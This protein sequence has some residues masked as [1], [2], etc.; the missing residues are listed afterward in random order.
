[1]RIRLFK[2]DFRNESVT[3]KAVGRRSVEPPQ[4]VKSSQNAT[5]NEKNLGF[6]ILH[7]YLLRC[8]NALSTLES[9]S[10]CALMAKD[11][12]DCIKNQ[13]NRD[14]YSVIHEYGKD[15]SACANETS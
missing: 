8:E 15:L 9:P 11:A 7:R 14:K 10:R 4:E 13:K 1:M 6:E 2:G 12:L 3:D 5:Y